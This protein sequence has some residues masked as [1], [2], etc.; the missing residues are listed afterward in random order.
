MRQHWSREAWGT[1]S[2]VATSLLLISGLVL[3]LPAAISKIIAYGPAFLS[4]P[5]T[6]WI[7]AVLAIE[8]SLLWWIWRKPQQDEI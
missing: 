8:G 4:H 1:V 3:D 5:T 6:Y 7:A 2:V